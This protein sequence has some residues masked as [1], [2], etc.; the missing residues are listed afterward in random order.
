MKV[1]KSV[2]SYAL[3]ECALITLIIYITS[4]TIHSYNIANIEARIGMLALVNLIAYCYMQRKLTGAVLT[5]A[6]LFT[7]FLYLFNLGIPISRVLGWISKTDELFL[8]RR[9]YCM[10]EETFAHFLCYTFILISFLQIGIMHYNSKAKKRVRSTPSQTYYQELKICKQIGLLLLVIGIIPYAYQEVTTIKNAMLFTYQDSNNTFSLSGT[11]IG[12]FAGLFTVGYIMLMYVFQTNKKKFDFLLILMSIYQ[13]GRM[14]VTGDRSTGVVLI[15]VFLLMRHTLV[16]QI[17][18][19]KAGIF[20]IG[21]Y[22]GMMLLSLIEHTRANTTVVLSEVI[23]DL[24]QDNILASTVTEYGGNVWSGLM[25]YYSVPETGWFRCGLT[26]L[27]GIIGKP[28]SILNL[29]DSVWKFADFSNFINE[30]ARGSVIA[31]VR[32]AMGGSFTGEWW[33]NFGWFGI[34]LIPIFGY[35]LG[36]MSDYCVSKKKNPVLSSFLLYASTL[37]IWW[38]RQ[39]FTSV[40][41][42][43]MFYGMIVYISYLFFKRKSSRKL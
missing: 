18:G 43:I 35:Y 25:V 39:Y 3:F 11:G 37:I 19:I 38:V 10:G 33:F 29:T 7:I 6:S 21:A 8:N 31:V 32:S 23:E 2:V 15:L 41:W 27:A 17:K 1:K 36:K 30:D 28:L 20:V 40:S 12:L 42:N 14:Y 16:S 5:V 34:V 13:V 4:D 9:I 22:F 24:L 26:Y